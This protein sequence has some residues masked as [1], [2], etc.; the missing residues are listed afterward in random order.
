M[1]KIFLTGGSG[2]VGKAFIKKYYEKYKFYSFSRGEKSQV[3]LKRLF[4]DVE[5]ILGSVDDYALLSSEI[6]KVCPDIVIHAAALKH[7]DTAEKQPSLVVQ[8]NIIGSLNIIKCSQFANVPLTIAI[9][10]DKACS[11]D[12]LYGYSKYF[13]EKMFSEANNSKSRF[14]SCRFGNVA[15]SNGSVLPFWFAQHEQNKELWL[16]D[17]RM[18][19]LMFTSDEAAELINKCINL[20]KV[21][22]DGFILSKKMKTVNMFELSKLISKKIKIVGLRAGEKIDEDLISDEELKFS[23]ELNDY[24]IIHDYINKN[25]STRL[26]KSLSSQSAVKM[27]KSEMLSLIKNV[28]NEANKSNLDT[29]LY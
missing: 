11:P 1:K 8:A 20:T 4:P 12:N 10:T 5:I 18:N 17:K 3:A 24:V 23:F 14:I 25:E 21:H 29:K 7:V 15:W 16:T 2:T 28:S 27:N 9:S 13:M 26:Q 6:N 19:R 22:S